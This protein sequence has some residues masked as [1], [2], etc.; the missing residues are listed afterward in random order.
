MRTSRHVPLGVIRPIDRSSK[1]WSRRLGWDRLVRRASTFANDIAGRNRRGWEPGLGRSQMIHLW[2]GR[3]R[4][5]EPAIAYRSIQLTLNLY[6]KLIKPG[7]A[8]KPKV[9]T[10]KHGRGRIAEPA[11][12]FEKR[13][14]IFEHTRVSWERTVPL[15]VWKKPWAEH[16][17]HPKRQA[18]SYQEASSLRGADASKPLIGLRRSGLDQAAYRSIRAAPEWESV[19]YAGYAAPTL[20]FRRDVTSFRHQWWRSVTAPTPTVTKRGRGNGERVARWLNFPR[21]WRWL[22]LARSYDEARTL[23]AASANRPNLI[24]HTDIVADQPRR[25]RISASLEVGSG[26]HAGEGGRSGQF[27]RAGSLDLARVHRGIFLPLGDRAGSIGRRQWP[28]DRPITLHALARRGSAFMVSSERRGTMLTSRPSSELQTERRQTRWLSNARSTLL[29][30]ALFRR[31]FQGHKGLHGATRSIPS[32]DAF[33]L[34]DHRLRRASVFW[35]PNAPGDL[36]GAGGVIVGRALS[37]PSNERRTSENEPEADDFS[38][39]SR[40]APSLPTADLHASLETLPFHVSRKSTI[41]APGEVFPPGSKPWLRW[42]LAVGR[43]P[44][45]R[46]VHDRDTTMPGSQTTAP[47]ALSSTR[48]VGSR[49]IRRAIGAKAVDIALAPWTVFFAAGAPRVWD[50][51]RSTPWSFRTT[52]AERMPFRWS[53]PDD[54][55]AARKL[56]SGT[57]AAMLTRWVAAH[58][59]SHAT[60]PVAGGDEI[61]PARGLD[62][63][64]ADRTPTSRYALGRTPIP[65]LRSREVLANLIPSGNG[66]A[67]NRRPGT[68]IWPSEIAFAQRTK[69]ERRDMPFLAHIVT[70]KT[71][72]DAGTSIGNARAETPEKISVSP[73]AMASSISSTGRIAGDS[74]PVAVLADSVYRMIV[75]RVARDLRMRGR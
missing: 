50:Q 25:T 8:S 34:R 6:L 31:H 17:I 62:I 42:T 14:V 61:A 27:R 3:P 44:N 53:A 26:D 24:E 56:E 72:N 47:L 35:A 18:S 68:G 20:P 29:T 48:M 54:V 58:P 21:R 28:A 52:R 67:G 64:Q 60:T 55:N 37:F 7:H 66:V 23:P 59:V 15:D 22:S 36:S 73:A 41:G 46:S 71:G 75:D 12:P 32:I 5:S 13:T 45:R 43:A 70:A 16:P 4:G 11:R 39:T 38:N 57:P 9:P 10:R 49:S 69:P 63:D 51:P 33:A 19:S 30:Y 1:L 2:R 40:R 65:P 74:V